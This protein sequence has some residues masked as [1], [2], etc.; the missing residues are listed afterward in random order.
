MGL[1]LVSSPGDPYLD[2]RCSVLNECKDERTHTIL[3]IKP[4]YLVIANLWNLE[5][6]P[7]FAKDK[8][9]RRLLYPLTV[10]RYLK[11]TR[12]VLVSPIPTVSDFNLKFTFVNKYFLRNWYFGANFNEYQN[13]IREILLLRS[14]N[15]NHFSLIDPSLKIC[16]SDL[17]DLL[18][19]GNAIYRDSAHL[20]PRGAIF[21][22]GSLSVMN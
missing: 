10:N 13:E 14:R 2:S 19:D 4:D 20:T 16:K 12:L 7:S 3:D 15:A 1:F 8:F 9:E 21:A 17:C 11:N 18:Y 22:I 5:T 6:S